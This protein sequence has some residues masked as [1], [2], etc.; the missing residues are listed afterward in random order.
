MAK[1]DWSNISLKWVN[2]LLG[3]ISTWHLNKHEIF[4]VFRLI[5]LWVVKSLTF[6]SFSKLITK[7][8]LF[9]A[10]CSFPPARDWE[11]W[12]GQKLEAWVLYET[13]KRKPPK[14]RKVSWKW[15]WL[16]RDLQEVWYLTER[17]KIGQTYSVLGSASAV[18][19][20]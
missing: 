7:L 12:R 16:A 3:P 2:Y 8:S 19:V 4:F 11:S 1:Y 9:T 20:F 15:N 18:L 13:H 14:K 10:V 6:I 17:H 5:D